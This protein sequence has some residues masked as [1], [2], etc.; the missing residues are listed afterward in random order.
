VVETVA[1]ETGVWEVLVQVN[2]HI[3]SARE[4]HIF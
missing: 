2:L 1:G 4:V 3:S